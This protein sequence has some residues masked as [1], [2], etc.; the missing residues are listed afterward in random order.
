MVQ[1]TN[2]ELFFEFY[3]RKQTLNQVFTDGF[4][5]FWEKMKKKFNNG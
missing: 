2:I 3:S 5:C 1:S 4:L